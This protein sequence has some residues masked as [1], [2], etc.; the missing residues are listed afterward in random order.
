MSNLHSAKKSAIYWY[1][2]EII[3][4]LDLR[5]QY[6]S[7]F[8]HTNSNF[9]NKH[10]IAYL[11]LP[12]SWQSHSKIVV[13]GSIH[14][15][16][17]TI[18][19]KLSLSSVCEIRPFQAASRPIVRWLGIHCRLASSPLLSTCVWQ[20]NRGASNFHDCLSKSGLEAMLQIWVPLLLK[21]IVVYG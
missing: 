12:S 8:M 3:E 19:M 10:P 7:W 9:R 2:A 16:S 1:G 6:F 21:L 13:I 4:A 18:W 15:S 14:S 17:R 5:N 20:L 11:H